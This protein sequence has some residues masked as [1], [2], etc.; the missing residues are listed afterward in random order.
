MENVSDKIELPD[1][2][3]PLFGVRFSTISLFISRFIANFVVKFSS[4]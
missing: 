1:V 4:I 3:N 2:K